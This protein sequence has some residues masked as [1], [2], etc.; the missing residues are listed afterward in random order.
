[1]DILDQL[2]TCTKCGLDKSINYYSIDR[3]HADGHK[4]ICKG[5]TNSTRK[6]IPQIQQLSDKEKFNKKKI[7]FVNFFN[8]EIAFPSGTLTDKK[9]QCALETIL[10]QSQPCFDKLKETIVDCC[11]YICDTE[12]TFTINRNLFP[13]N[14]RLDEISTTIKSYLSLYLA[15][16]KQKFNIVIK[17]IEKDSDTIQIELSDSI[18]LTKEDISVFISEYIDPLNISAPLTD[19]IS[20]TYDN[21]NIEFFKEIYEIRTK[22]ALEK[23]LTEQTFPLIDYKHGENIIVFKFLKPIR[24]E[25]DEIDQFKLD[26]VEIMQRKYV[27][28]DGE[29]ILDDLDD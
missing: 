13:I 17:V 15:T 24:L 14:K 1:M 21:Y 7:E 10:E 5:C 29:L 11:K 6:V 9:R 12:Y 2:K 4:N 27:R 20:I 28:V 22:F 23:N 18:I 25:Q 26:V 16:S 19:E 8:E 3:T